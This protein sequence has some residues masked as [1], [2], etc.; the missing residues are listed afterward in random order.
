MTRLFPIPRAPRTPG[1]TARLR[2]LLGP[3]WR[4]QR[5]GRSIDLDWREGKNCPT[6]EVNGGEWLVYDGHGDRVGSVATIEHAAEVLRALVGQ[7]APGG[8]E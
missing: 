5:R 4:V 7:C 8:E 3:E 6:V 1:P 2:A